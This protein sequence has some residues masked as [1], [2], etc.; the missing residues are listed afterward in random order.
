[1]KILD[2]D[3]GPL[4]RRHTDHTYY[5]VSEIIVNMDVYPCTKPVDSNLDANNEPLCRC[6]ERLAVHR[7]RDHKHSRIRSSCNG[8][9]DC[10]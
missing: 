10:S 6:S 1:M 3:D 8:H 5:H 4:H 9:D 2:V 7:S